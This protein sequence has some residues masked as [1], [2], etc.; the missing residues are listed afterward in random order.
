[1]PCRIERAN[2]VVDVFP[3][4]STEPFWHYLIQRKQIIDLVKFDS[5]E[6]ALEAATEMLAKME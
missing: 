6:Q 5:Y 1:M 2:Y 3:A 4:G